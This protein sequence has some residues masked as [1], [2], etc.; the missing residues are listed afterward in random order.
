ML[1]RKRERGPQTQH[2][3]VISLTDDEPLCYGHVTVASMPH[4]SAS[5]IPPYAHLHQNAF[6]AF[7]GK[8]SWSIHQQVEHQ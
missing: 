7:H 6:Y 4:A 5:D 2:T 8:F 3:L 1:A